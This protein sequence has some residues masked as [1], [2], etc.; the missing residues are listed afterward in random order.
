MKTKTIMAIAMCFLGIQ[1]S[2]QKTNNSEEKEESTSS[3]PLD[4]LIQKKSD[5]YVITKEHISSISK[6][7]HV[8]LRQA[9]SGLEVAGT[10]SSVHID[11]TGETIASHNNFVNEIEAT[12][13]NATQ[14]LSAEQA[15][16]SVVQQMGYNLKS[17]QQLSSASGINK[18]ALYSKAGISSEEI[19]VKLMYL[20]QEGIGTSLVWELSVAELTSSDWWNFKVDATTGNIISKENW[21]NYCNLAHDHS[22]NAIAL[23]YNANLFDIPNY[24]STTESISAACNECYEVFAMPL[25]NPF[26]GGRSTVVN[27]ANATASPFGWH[28]TDGAAGA[29]FTV[30]QGNNVN[31]YENGDNPGYQPDPGASLEFT[32]YPFSQTYTNANQYED[33]AITN[34]FYWNNII[35]DVLYQ[36][37]FDEGAGNFQ[38]NNYGNG[39]A[40]SDSVNAEAQEGSE[41]CNARFGTPVDGS[42]P[43]MRMFLCGDKDGDFDN[44]VIAHEYGH[45]ISN[46]LTGGAGDSD[47]LDNDEQMGEGWSDFYGYMLTMNS[48]D[49]GTFA[50]GVGT[51]LF[52][53]GAN[54]SGIRNFMYSTD[55]GVNPHTY[56]DI[57]TTGGSPHDLGE[58]WAT[59]LWDL[60]WD[61]I[62]EHGFNTNF[63]NFT[64]DVNQDA[65]NI[66]AMAIVT[67]AMK[68]QPC[69][70]GF[71]DGRD[72]IFA[73]DAAI[74]GG[75]NE[76]IIWGAFARRGLGLSADQ[77]D[78]DDRTDG[79]EA[80]DTPGPPTAVCVAPFDL[81]L[82]A[83][84]MASLTAADIDN[85]SFDSCGIES[86]TISKENF[87]CSDVGNNVITLIVT[88]T[89][90][91]IDTCDTTVTITK[92]PTT[93]TY[94]GDLEGQYTD[95]VTL[96]AT[97]LDADGIGVSGKS[98]SFTIGTQVTAANTDT[99]GQ[100]STVLILDQE[101]GN[102]SV[103]VEFVEDACFLGSTDSD[104]FEI[105]PEDA[106]VEYT[107]HTIQATPN[108]N[109]SEAVVVLSA[110]I[111]EVF[112]GYPGDIRNATITFVNRDDNTDI[113]PAI[114]VTDLFD[115][116]D[117][118][119]GTV[120][121]EWLVDIGNQTSETFT[122]GIVVGGC[123]TRD[124]SDDNS[125]LTI[126]KPVGDF[127]TG[128]GYIIPD[129]SEG[130]Y[131]STAGLKS[132]FGFNVK[133]NK[134]GRRLKGN[135]NIIFRILEGDGV[136]TYQIKGNA[137]Q[138]LGVDIAD[139]ENKKAEFMTKANLKDV[140]DP[141]NHISLGGNHTLSID[142]T[143][144]GE[145]GEFDSIGITLTDSNG[146]L[147]YSSNWI[148]IST[149][150]MVLT[151]GN[152]VVH[153]GFSTTS[154]LGFDD[155]NLGL[156]SIS[157]YPNP[158]TYQ[159]TLSNPNNI[160]LERLLIYDLM[161]RLVQSIDIS[162][163]GLDQTISISKL[164]NSSYILIIKTEQGQITKQLIK[165]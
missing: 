88:D 79:T 20:Y 60:T 98:I 134:N 16:S 55:M 115:P 157:I 4:Q 23:D 130:V 49:T 1:L 36:Y 19:P 101:P 162:N 50:R 132:N 64:G 18:K 33:S 65:G 71:V 100:A 27:P 159:V 123:Y 107:G 103:D 82:D 25:E 51:Y 57:K 26:Y 142:M 133:Y 83:N 135:S 102:Y 62:D 93:L 124:S 56:D 106:I 147:L 154:L 113:S 28:D 48:G 120:S 67:E 52:N 22:T 116:S 119:T 150:E 75:A 13:K 127:I 109:S 35:H 97:L 96:S 43:R 39:G 105:M 126:Y 40:G 45:G 148:G 143:D 87:D 85:G 2:A 74:Y 94:D 63:Y 77:G 29:E 160:E 108:K 155:S 34:L 80:F 110:N 73:A 89:H 41:T 59:M 78:T 158:A 66:M 95:P 31:A 14:S 70:P 32:G 91:N 68:I 42:N 149:D 76:C 145:P 81:Q 44:L 125:I 5:S 99:N 9:I 153:S 72:A 161:G 111:Q 164:A 122:I 131:A 114:P 3:I 144:R 10:E 140:T 15:I 90:G 137:I 117:P 21:T 92:H 112:D 128:G 58:V 53:H 54:G 7:R 69:S 8:Y 104:P 129:N 139:E 38:E 151:G 86:I 11:K 165:E 163:M 46:R 156:T 118:T 24:D 141:L 17:L 152:L 84:G 146:I 37:G 138:S 12:V 6:I 121:Y 61:L 136:H 47:C 30:T